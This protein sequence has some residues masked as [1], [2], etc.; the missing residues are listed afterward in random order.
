MGIKEEKKELRLSMLS[1]RSLLRVPS[2]SKYDKWICKVVFEDLVNRN[3]KVV[4]CYLP[5]KEEINI[6]PLIQK[7]LDAKIKVICPKTLLKGQLSHHEL[8]S[9]EE[10]EEGLFSTFH[11][12]TKM[13]YLGKIDYIIV[14]GLAF[15]RKGNRLGY[16]G[17]YYDRFLEDHKEAYKVG[18]AY[19]FQVIDNVPIEPFDAVL[20]QIY[21]TA[22]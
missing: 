11:P 3:S 13:P 15:D 12:K 22:L 14:P 7:L 4:H 8:F 1:E 2:K 18:L 21:F 5:M 16:G 10:I 9:L 19:P 20:D 6:R 17:G